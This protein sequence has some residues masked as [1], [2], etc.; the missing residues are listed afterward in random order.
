M[1]SPSVSQHYKKL[2]VVFL[3]LPA[4]WLIS[5]K[6]EEE[7]PIESSHTTQCATETEPPGSAKEPMQKSAVKKETKASKPGASQIPKSQTELYYTQLLQQRKVFL[8][9]RVDDSSA[10][11]LI[12]QLLYL[13]QL[14]STQPII[15]FINSGGGRVTSGLA[16]YD[17]MQYIQA[18]VHTVCVGHAESMAAILLAAGAAGQR[19]ALPNSRIMI[20][21]ASHSMEGKTTDITIRAK[22]AEN[23]ARQ[24]SDI[25]AH[26]T[27][28]GI[29]DVESAVRYDNNMSPQEALRFGLIDAIVDRVSKPGAKLQNGQQ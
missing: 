15:L 27:G 12:A 2:P 10:Q 20:H 24:L 23:I 14:S 7:E 1:Q 17:V 25:I 21:Q 4:L 13:D 19:R 18:P 26:H 28:L 16:I 9:G 29:E 11:E 8:N 5:G 3:A 22:K 6:S